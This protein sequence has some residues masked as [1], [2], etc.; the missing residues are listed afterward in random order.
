MNLDVTLS[1]SLLI[2]ETLLE[3]G[4]AQRQF[5]A[6]PKHHGGLKCLAASR[7][8]N[9]SK[10][11]HLNILPYDVTRVILQESPEGRTYINASR[12]TIFLPNSDVGSNY[13]A[14]QAPI[15]ETIGDFW[16]MVYE[17]LSGMIVTLCNLSEKGTQACV[18]FWPNA[19]ECAEHGKLVVT[20]TH[21]STPSSG[22]FTRKSY[23][24]RE[25]SIFNLETQQELSVTQFHLLSWI[26]E[27]DG[28]KSN[29]K[30]GQLVDFL[31]DVRN[32]EGMSTGPDIIHCSNGIDRTG[33]YILADLGQSLIDHDQAIRP[34]ELL[35]QMRSQR[36]GMVSKYADFEFACN[37][38]LTSY[39][40]YA[41][42]VGYPSLKS[43]Y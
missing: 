22:Y 34:M 8:E 29:F 35:R 40:R 14:T 10:N 17:N 28:K 20:C 11:R 5:E 31:H 43:K 39:Q 9:R 4:E 2:L 6:V 19:S 36:P 13:I 24:I 38:I 15:P 41:R 16:Q 30:P 7:P 1:D 12:L 27:L 33:A 18:Q 32:Y 26:P 25:F 23:V 42:R 37:T 3:S 21:E